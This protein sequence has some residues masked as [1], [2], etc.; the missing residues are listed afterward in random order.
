[1]KISITK[2]NNYKTA[3]IMD[4]NWKRKKLTIPVTLIK[5][6][7]NSNLIGCCYVSYN[8][9]FNLIVNPKFRKQ[10]YGKK[11]ID[12][13]CKI[14]WKKYKYVNLVPQDNDSSL[15]KY[16]SSLGFI[17]YSENE[18]GYEAEDKNWWTMWKTKN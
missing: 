2:V 10:G 18:E 16:Y 14:I 6:R 5:L 13:A 12:A 7:E 15:R 9:I 11:I 17:G 4:F 3:S 8:W 1:M